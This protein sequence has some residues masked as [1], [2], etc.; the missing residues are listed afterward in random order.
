[1]EDFIAHS[2]VETVESLLP[3]GSG[4]KSLVFNLS[5]GYFVSEAEFR[6]RQSFSFLVNR[7][8]NYTAV[9]VSFD[10]KK[11]WKYL[12][13]HDSGW[14]DSI[15]TQ[16]HKMWLEYRDDL[17]NKLDEFKKLNVSKPIKPSV[18][19]L[20]DNVYAINEKVIIGHN[21]VTDPYIQWAECEHK[22]DEDKHKEVLTKFE[23]AK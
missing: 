17:W 3:R 19:C 23:I 9:F 6:R 12:S 20:V 7:D 18:E 14:R 2:I 1:M 21:L 10:N 8:C 16:L 4:K 13:Y 5:I 11:T 15:Q 22:P